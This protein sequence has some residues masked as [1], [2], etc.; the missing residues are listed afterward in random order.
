MREAD[1]SDASW[2]SLTLA[3]ASLSNHFSLSLIFLFFT[4]Y[5]FLEIFA[6]SLSYITYIFHFSLSLLFLFSIVA[7]F[8]ASFSPWIFVSLLFLFLSLLLPSFQLYFFLL[9]FSCEGRGY[10]IFWKEFAQ[11]SSF[12]SLFLGNI[13]TCFIFFENYLY[14][15]KHLCWYGGWYDGEGIWEI[16]RAHIMRLRV[17]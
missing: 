16:Y 7:I 11:L 1:T 15:L 8:V 2:Q 10:R 3:P 14:Y 17:W 5:S 13:G 4:L 6:A 12:D 9:T